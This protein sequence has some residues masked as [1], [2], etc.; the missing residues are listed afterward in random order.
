MLV[1]VEFY[2]K[3]ISNLG[4]RPK[5]VNSKTKLSSICQEPVWLMAKLLYHVVNNVLENVCTKH[6]V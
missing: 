3:G 1:S 5:L 6:D 2:F 4:S